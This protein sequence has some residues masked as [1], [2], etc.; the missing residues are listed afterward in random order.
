MKKDC[1]GDR[2]TL[3]ARGEEIAVAYLIRQKYRIIETNFRCRCGEVDIIARDGKTLVFVE[4][5]TRR[6]ASYGLPQLAVT[7]FKQRQISKAA[8]TYLSKNRLM[9]EN[10]RFDVV[11]IFLLDTSPTVDHIKNAFD[12]AY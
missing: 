11:S 10:A 6:T 1:S 5:K 7:P 8:L 4:V 12:L 3:G 2:K 9:E